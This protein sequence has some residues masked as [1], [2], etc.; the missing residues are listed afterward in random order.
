MPTIIYVLKDGNRKTVAA[1]NGKTL[2]EV[3]IANNVRGIDAECGGCCSCATCHVYVDEAWLGKLPALDDMENEL[4]DGVAAERT[5]SSR[6]SC[7]I[8]VNDALDGL[9][10]RIP[11]TQG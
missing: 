11:E 2:M 10:V 6:L 3:A 8:I 7:Q 9:V 1:A 5:G 4:L